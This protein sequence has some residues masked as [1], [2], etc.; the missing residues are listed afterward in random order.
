MEGERCNGGESE[1]E[2]KG[3]KGRGGRE[4]ERLTGQEKRNAGVYAKVSGVIG[5]PLK[6]TWLVSSTRGHWCQCH[7]LQPTPLGPLKDGRM[8]P[9][10]RHNQEQLFM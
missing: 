4:Q 9:R 7:Q 8:K 10:W 2:S 1:R 5:S 3:G 6:V